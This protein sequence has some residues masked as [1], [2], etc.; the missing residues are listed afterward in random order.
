V[1]CLRD[2]NVLLVGDAAGLAHPI[3][4]GGIAP[5][6]ISGQLAGQAVAQAIAGRNLA[7]LDRYPQEWEATM[8]APQR[9]ALANRRYLDAHWSDDPVALSAAVA[10]TWIAFPAYGW[11]KPDISTTR[12]Q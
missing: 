9:Q 1:A 7:A 6:V 8:G 5:A 10:E 3:T 4:G 12:G 2:G 11:R